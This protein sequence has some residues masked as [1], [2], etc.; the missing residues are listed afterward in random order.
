VLKVAG[1]RFTSLAVYFDQMEL[2]IQLGLAQA[3]TT[4]AS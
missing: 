1:D 3:P 2:L 4:Q